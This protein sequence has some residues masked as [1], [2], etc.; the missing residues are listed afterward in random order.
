L[1]VVDL[2]PPRDGLVLV[3]IVARPHGL[4]GDVIVNPETDF[5]AERFAPGAEVLV[6]RGSRVEPLKVATLRFHQQRPIVGFDG[7]DSIETV[8]WLAQQ[9]LWVREEDRPPLDEGLFYHSDLIGCRVQTVAGGEV[10][11]V[12]RIDGSAGVPLLVVA[13]AGAANG[14]EGVLIP[15]AEP[16]CRVIDVSNR[17]IVVDPP[18][19]LL[20]LNEGRHG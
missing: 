5:A 12:A 14:V 6:A 3:G 8:Q 17:R 19:G 7:F 1:L 16:I 18:E 4:R 11:T 13:P 15:L 9:P 2:T 10:G 20:E